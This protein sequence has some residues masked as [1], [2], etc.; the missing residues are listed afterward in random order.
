MDPGLKD[1]QKKTKHRTM[2]ILKQ[3]SNS[4]YTLQKK[5][6]SK[7]KLAN[8]RVHCSPS[9]PFKLLHI[10][11]ENMSISIFP[12]FFFPSLILIGAGSPIHEKLS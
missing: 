11:Q 2:Y 5:F 12:F 3:T 4:T 9:A 7:K 8:S 6:K 1:V 10:L